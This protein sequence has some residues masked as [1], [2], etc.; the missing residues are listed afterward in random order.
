MSHCQIASCEG[1]ISEHDEL[2]GAANSEEV[3]GNT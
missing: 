2:I 1:I 3:R